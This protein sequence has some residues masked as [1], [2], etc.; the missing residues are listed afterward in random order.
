MICQT[1]SHIVLPVIGLKSDFRVW[2][3]VVLYKR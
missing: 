3:L 1:G 2:V